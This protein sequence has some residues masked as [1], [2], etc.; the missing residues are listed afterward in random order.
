VLRARGELGVPI[1]FVGV[2]ETLD[3]LEPFDA[4]RFADR[5]LGA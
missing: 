1:R 5:V 3:D 2:G 4:D